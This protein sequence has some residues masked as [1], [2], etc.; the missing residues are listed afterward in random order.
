MTREEF[1]TLAVTHQKALRRF[2]MGACCGD[3]ALA[4]D[5]A[6]EALLK[7]YIS[8]DTL[9]DYNK[10]KPWLYRIAVN[11][12]I[13]QYRKR[14]Y[15]VG[16]SEAATTVSSDT[17]D[18]AFRYEALYRALDCLSEKERS[19]VLLYYM[20]G[21]PT[22]EIAEITGASEAAVKQQLSRGRKH[23]RELLN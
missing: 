11:I 13:S 9:S 5:I 18:A 3:A 23:L 4:D 8:I 20:E 17:P 2:L 1:I 6:Q 10:F 19:A 12:F 7:A 21:Y 16:Y 15:T 14:L 22:K